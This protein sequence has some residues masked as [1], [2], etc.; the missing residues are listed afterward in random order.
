MSFI[1][2]GLD[3]KQFEHLRGASDEELAA[4]HIERTSADGPGFP[5]RITLRDLPAGARVL[6]LNYEHQPAS[7]P[8]RASHAIFIGEDEREAALYR[9]EIPQALRDRTL[10]LRA[11]DAAGRM[12]DAVLIDGKTAG[13]AIE[14]LL[15]NADVA[16]VHAHYATRGCY[17]ALIERPA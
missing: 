12:V 9:D 1:I 14:R 4:L 13:A 8:Y 3:P 16:Y 11:F 2:S 17:A 6:L 10:S 15:A 7:T 5:D